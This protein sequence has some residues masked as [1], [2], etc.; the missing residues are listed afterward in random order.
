[1]IKQMVV[2]VDGVLTNGK[3]YIDHTGEKL[4]KAFHSRDIRAI[5]EIVARGIE[6][7][8]LTA[9]AW[10]GAQAWAYRVGATFEVTRDKMKYIES[11]GFKGYETVAVGDDAWD[12]QMLACAKFAYAPHDADKSLHKV[13]DLILLPAKGGE[14]VMA[15]LV[16]SARDEGWL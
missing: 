5:R 11:R 1:M 15:A 6:V 2:D 7:V 8:I 3:Q 12:V 16:R 9:D 4:F 13:E 14:G 10:P